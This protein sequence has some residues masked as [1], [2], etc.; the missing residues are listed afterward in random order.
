VASENDTQNVRSCLHPNLSHPSGAD[1]IR[2]SN[3][4]LREKHKSGSTYELSLPIGSL[5][6]I[7]ASRHL[8][9]LPLAFANTSCYNC[10]NQITPERIMS[11][12][13][14]AR[15]WWSKKRF[16]SLGLRV[17][18][19]SKARIIKGPC[20]SAELEALK[21]LRRAIHVH[22]CT[23]GPQNLSR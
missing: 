20:D 9:Q 6:I 1:E 4:R 5:K 17:V 3:W 19:V 11:L 18:R 12:Y 21:Y 2:K 15:L 16:G 13:L 22:T 23:Q 8:S 10:L 7:C 14:R